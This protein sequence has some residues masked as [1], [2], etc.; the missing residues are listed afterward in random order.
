MTRLHVKNWASFQHY[1][2]RAPPWIKL[3]KGLLDNL[4]FANLSPLAGKCLPLVWLIASE[5]NGAV[6]DVAV[7]AFRLRV[8]VET[9]QSVLSDLMDHGFICGSVDCAAVA[10]A[11]PKS[12]PSRY[13]P[14]KVRTAVMARDNGRCVWCG[15]PDDIEFDHIIPVSRGG[16]PEIDNIQLLCRSCNR[17]KR[18]KVA[19]QA[20]QLATQMQGRR[21]LETEVE[22]EVE[23]ENALRAL[24]GFSDPPAAADGEKPKRQAVP[25]AAIVDLYHAKLPELPK[26]EKLTPARRG[27]LQQRWRED[28][29]DLDQWGNFFDH[30]RLSKF[31]MGKA[32]GKDGKPP[33]R[34]DLEWLTKPANFAK[35]AED[36]YHR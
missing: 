16:S 23:T 3:H 5:H 21:S 19:E 20:E 27:Y 22:T 17:K 35:I 28:L 25:I 26:V 11:L 30:I 6:P 8:S 36:K 18:T 32:P 12:N 33:F 15:S 4:D 9:A 10:P 14:D 24:V 31:L 7:V 1:R 34:A 2:D 29:L 13:I